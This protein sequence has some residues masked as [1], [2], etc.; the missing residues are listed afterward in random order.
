MPILSALLLC[1][2]LAGAQ[3]LVPSL[4]SGPVGLGAGTLAPL[5][6]PGGFPAPG[7]APLAPSLSLPAASLPLP[8]G[9]LPAVS[10]E[11]SPV[12]AFPAGTAAPRAAG[13]LPR[14]E[15]GD[16]I[17]LDLDCGPLCDAMAEV[18]REQFGGEGPR[19][20]H[21]GIVEV[22]DGTPFVWEAWPGKGVVR[23]PLR[24]FLGRVKGGEE[25]PG[26][27]YVGRLD[28]S[29]RAL[30]GPALDRVKAASGLPYDPAFSW[31]GPGMYC[32]KLVAL[33]FADPS[34][35][36][37]RPMFFGR[38]G[39]RSREVWRE[40]F[41]ARGMEIPDGEPGV[42]PLGIYLDGGA[43]LFS[44]QAGAPAS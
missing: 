14:V 39:S 27:F 42:S 21:V 17:F 1:V 43:Q 35:L 44:P 19:L 16:L 9:V 3:T 25:A 26:G 41:A 6:P 23:V 30:A 5:P 10:A 13:P 32:S 40:Y 28:P 15:S 24:L 38:E 8:R 22:R 31:D 4:P 29:R 36:R 2:S 20:T 11:A 34:L 37:P 12:R 33:A 7:P 18:T